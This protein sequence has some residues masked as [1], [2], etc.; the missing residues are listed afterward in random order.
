MHHGFEVFRL[1]RRAAQDE[2]LA[3]RADPDPSGERVVL[4]VD[5]LGRIGGFERGGVRSQPGGLGM[6]REVEALLAVLQSYGAGLN[7]TTILKDRDRSGHWSRI[8]IGGRDAECERLRL[9]QRRRHREVGYGD[10]GD[11]AR[12][13]RSKNVQPHSSRAN[14]AEGALRVAVVFPSV[15]HQHHRAVMCGRIGGDFL[16]RSFEVSRTRCARGASGG[17]VQL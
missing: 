1:A 5:I 17:R 16:Q 7:R 11:A 13:G 10:V 3:L 4:A 8:V 15:G 6:D 2:H 9:G 14:R 12:A